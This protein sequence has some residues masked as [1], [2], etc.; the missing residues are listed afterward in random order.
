MLPHRSF[1]LRCLPVR[2]AGRGVT[3]WRFSLQEA[4]PEAQQHA[5]NALEDLV[6][7]LSAELGQADPGTIEGRSAD[8]HPRRG[9]QE[10]PR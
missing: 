6:A 10:S 5:F 8:I 2:R 1:V 3:T 7:F 4:E 9:S